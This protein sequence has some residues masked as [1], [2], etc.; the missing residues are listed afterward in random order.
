MLNQLCEQGIIINYSDCSVLEV[1]D[2]NSTGFVHSAVES[3]KSR[4]STFVVTPE[5]TEAWRVGF[6]W[7]HD[8]S[9]KISLLNPNWRLLAEFSAPLISGR[10]DLVI[11]TGS[12]LLVVEMKTG[13]KPSKSTGEKQV[14][15]YAETLW[16]K[17]KIGRFRTVVPI[18]L[19]S[20]KNVDTF[21]SLSKFSK[22]VC[23][24]DV[25]SL[26]IDSLIKISEQIFKNDNIARDFTGDNSK[27][28]K[29]SPRPTVVEA[30]I[31][32][33]AALDD[34]NVTTG[35]ADT[36]EI[37]RIIQIIRDRAISVAA[38]NLHEII[39][40][41]G[42]PGAGK[43]LVGLRIAHDQRIQGILPDDM[44]TPLYLTGNGPLVEVLVESLARDEVKRLGN[45][46]TTAISNANTKVRLIHSITEDKLGIESNIIV[47]DEGQRIWTEER[48]QQKK[49]DKTLGSEAEE[50][51]KYL[52]KLPWSLAIVLI[53]EGQE[54]NAGEAGLETW[55]KAVAKQ[56]NVFASRWK[57]TIPKELNSPDYDQ[58]NIVIDTNLSL[59]SIQRTDNAA[60]V[61]TWVRHFLNNEFLK[62]REVRKEF[63]E[64][65]IF[66][67]R[68]LAKAKSWLK[69]KANDD[70][71]RCGLVASSTS[72]RL[73]LYGID[74][75][76]SA[77]RGFNWANW[78]L[79][80][81]P[82]LSSSKA[83]EVTASE[84]KCQGLEL[85]LVGVCWSWDMV[86]EGS[87]WQARTLRADKAN[88]KR[89]SYK[90]FKFQFQLNAYRVLLTRSRKGM[91]IWIP[92][93]DQTDSSRDC[94]E[95]NLVA[96]TFRE[97]GISEII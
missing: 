61:S 59:K 34:R 97:S 85:D 25:L 93:G 78:Y 39:V 46:K 48:M 10:P 52:A 67:T 11:D 3:M 87:R 74:A 72:K 60:D 7:I 22:D 35:L 50:I 56:N 68:D 19:A 88:W 62:A 30:A 21:D 26:T 17:L 27:L 53:G 18:V 24:T 81:L 15:E 83:L 65:P 6:K 23:P 55:V 64:F 45:K 33:V 84:Y 95:M 9:S 2:L 77:E 66:F 86:L 71:L 38:G 13:H 91:V 40:V 16:G 41:S 90:T 80:D 51:L 31:S 69:E 63:S 32:L 37:N 47:F 4:F 28:M 29:Y 36:E 96:N 70:N 20:K 1:S 14:L 82:D 94:D 5:Q 54:I 73:T 8:Y 12:F 44:G 42:A 89:T 49:R 79:N 75:F 43:T 58:S 76:S 92:N 57:I